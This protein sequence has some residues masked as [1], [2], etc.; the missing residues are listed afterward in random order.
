MTKHGYLNYQVIDKFPNVAVV[1]AAQ[2]EQFSACR[3]L[4]KIAAAE[5]TTEERPIASIVDTELDHMHHDQWCNLEKMATE[6]SCLGGEY[7]QIYEQSSLREND[8]HSYSPFQVRGI[9]FIYIYKNNPS[10]LRNS[11]TLLD[12]RVSLAPERL[13]AHVRP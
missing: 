9:R 7:R 5:T 13:A 1:M 2:L 3:I 4:S 8:S 11:V 12:L 10:Q 6:L